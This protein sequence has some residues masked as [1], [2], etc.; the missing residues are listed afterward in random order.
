M[1]LTIESWLNKIPND[2]TCLGEPPGGLCD[3]GC[4]CFTSLEVF[5]SLLFDIIPHPSVNYHRVFTPIL[6]FQPSSSQS[7]LP[8]FHFNFS[9]LFIFT[10]SATVSSGLFL[11]TGVFL[12]Y[13]PSFVTQTRAGTPHPRSSTV[14]ALTELSLPAD[15]WPWTTNVWIIRPLVYQL[16]QWTTKYRVKIELLNIFRLFKIIWK[17]YKNTWTRFDKKCCLKLLR[18]NFTSKLF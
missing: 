7:D 5:H 18:Q 10:V 11:P 6:Y 9:G 2:G 17:D 15:A 1:S 4:C 16:R 8:H 12:P 14:P 3:V 13:V